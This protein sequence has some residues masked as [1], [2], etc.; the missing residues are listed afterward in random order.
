MNLLEKLSQFNPVPSKRKQLKRRKEVLAQKYLYGLSGI[1]IGGSGRDFGLANQKG[2]YANIDI[3][4]A[5]TRAQSKGWRKSQLVNIL[6]SGD[7]LPL[8]NDVVEY[9]FN[10]HV[11]E[12]FFDPIKAIQEWYRVLK[13]GGY[14]FMII[15]HKERTFDKK[16]DLTSIEELINRH[17]HKLTFNDYAHRSPAEKIKFETNEDKDHHL[18][19][20]NNTVPAGWERFSRY[21]FMHHWSVWNTANFLALCEKM[22]WK[23]VEYEDIDIDETAN[24]FAIVL[25]K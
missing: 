15:P 6:A 12:H 19:I 23:V 18:L 3:I 24:E 20:E 1:E 2:S 5:E 4:D 8:K 14:L 10:S 9:V 21:D 13:K 22:N 17:E 11:I 25:Q 16:R 7:D